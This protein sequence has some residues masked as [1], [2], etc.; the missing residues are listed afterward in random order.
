L[1][2]ITQSN[3]GFKTMPLAIMRNS[4]RFNEVWMI[5]PNPTWVLKQGPYLHLGASS[6]VALKEARQFGRFLLCEMK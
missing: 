4:H 2:N 1:D 6:K 5:L 3:L